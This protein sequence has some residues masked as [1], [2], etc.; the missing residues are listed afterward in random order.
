MDK[1]E[2]G[3]YMAVEKDGISGWWNRWQSG[4][5]KKMVICMVKKIVIWMF[6]KDG[7]LDGEIDDNQV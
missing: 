7:H 5:L 4:C 2:K 6:E 1:G 3:D